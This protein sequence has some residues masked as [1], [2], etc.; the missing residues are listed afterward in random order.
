VR[1]AAANVGLEQLADAMAHLEQ[2][3][4]GGGH[5][6]HPD[7][8]LLHA[9]LAQAASAVAA[10]LAA[11]TAGQEAAPADDST[12]PDGALDPQRAQRAGNA[13][14][15]ALRRGALD[16]AA[17]TSLATALAGHP[18]AARVAQVQDA[19]ADFD[20]KL[21][22]QQLEAVLAALGDNTVQEEHQ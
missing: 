21:A 6:C 11:A 22:Q 13:L 4:G 10:A 5:A 14:L 9:A 3:A 12:V 17:L 16:D 7:A 20:F 18:A 2:Q 1:G 19:L 8:P 15:Q